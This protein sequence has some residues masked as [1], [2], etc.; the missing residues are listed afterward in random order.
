MYI[1]THTYICIPI[2]TYAYIHTLY[3]YATPGGLI[4]EL[5]LRDGA[6]AWSL[7]T[8]NTNNKTNSN[9]ST[10]NNSKTNSSNNSNDNSN[11]SND[12]SNNSNDNSNDNVGRLL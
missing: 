5:V 2:D 1:Y 6:G 9:N 7:S 3:M 4:L 11:T 8:S 10:N 12:N